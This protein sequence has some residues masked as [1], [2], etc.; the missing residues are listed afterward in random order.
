MRVKL[1]ALVAGS[2]AIV[3]SSASGKPLCSGGTSSPGKRASMA[4]LICCDD[5]HPPFV[6]LTATRVA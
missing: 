3:S 2:E 6:L 5:G 1:C 4:A